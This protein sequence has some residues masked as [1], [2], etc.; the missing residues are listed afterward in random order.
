MKSHIL[1]QANPL[2]ASYLTGAPLPCNNGR[3]LSETQSVF[4]VWSE[5]QS[6]QHRHCPAARTA[7]ADFSILTL[8]T[9]SAWTAISLLEFSRSFNGTCRNKTDD[10]LGLTNSDYLQYVL[11]I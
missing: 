1:I 10:P 9:M 2:S 11:I 6:G 3:P 7:P 5:Q 8:R 4:S